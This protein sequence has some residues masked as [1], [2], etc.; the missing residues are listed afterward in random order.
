MDDQL[1]IAEAI[2]S[3][4]EDPGLRDV[5]IAASP[6]AVL[7]PFAQNVG[8]R[9]IAVAVFV[10]EAALQRHLLLSVC[11]RVYEVLKSRGILEGLD[12]FEVSPFVL[13]HGQSKRTFKLSVLSSAFDRVA[14]LTAGDIGNPKI[15]DDITCILYDKS[16]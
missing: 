14:E 6:Q 15:A 8:R 2:K 13:R 10:L 9:Y 16:L 3:I 5:V 1:R 7:M 12:G 11:K 4:A